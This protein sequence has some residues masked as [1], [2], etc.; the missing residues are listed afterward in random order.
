M[1]PLKRPAGEE[2]VCD[3][4]DANGRTGKILLTGLFETASRSNLKTILC[5]DVEPADST[6]RRTGHAQAAHLNTRGLHQ[7]ISPCQSYA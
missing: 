1:R 4:S 5:A 7:A 3:A 6:Q 2:A